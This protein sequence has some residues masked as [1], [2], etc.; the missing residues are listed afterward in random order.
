MRNTPFNFEKVTTAI[1]ESNIQ[2]LGWATIREIVRIVN[3][4]ECETGEKYIRMEMG[5]PGLTPPEVGTKAEIEAL[6]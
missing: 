5:V 1:N 3:T 2:D 4:I 6:Q